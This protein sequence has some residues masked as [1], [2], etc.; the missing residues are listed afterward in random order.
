MKLNENF[1]QLKVEKVSKFTNI[2]KKNYSI[3]LLLTF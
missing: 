3:E 1:R 2:N